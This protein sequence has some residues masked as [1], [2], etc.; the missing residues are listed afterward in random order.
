M[1]KMLKAIPFWLGAKNT[2]MKI[3]VSKQQGNRCETR[4]MK[5]DGLVMGKYS[6]VDFNGVQ[7]SLSYKA[8][9]N[10]GFVP[11]LDNF[12]KESNKKVRYILFC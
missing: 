1:E 12:S 7:R 4:L 3:Q 6:Y 5:T 2:D 9:A 10:I 11:N 8:G